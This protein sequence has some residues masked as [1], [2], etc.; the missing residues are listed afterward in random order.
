MSRLAVIGA[1]GDLIADRMLERE[2]E[3]VVYKAYDSAKL[4]KASR[5]LSVAGAAGAVAG[6]R[7]RALR[8]ASGLS[9]MAASACTRFGVFRAGIASAQDP[10]ATVEPQRR[11]TASG[12]AAG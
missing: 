12:E 2:L 9:L 10:Q 7:S 11:L 4:L 1:M 5:V 8:I 6:T 3:A